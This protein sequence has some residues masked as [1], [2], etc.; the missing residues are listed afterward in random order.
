MPVLKPL[1]TG[2]RSLVPAARLEAGPILDFGGWRGSPAP[3][4]APYILHLNTHRMLDGGGASGG[5]LGFNQHPTSNIRLLNAQSRYLAASRQLEIEN[6]LGDEHGCKHVGE[7]A[8]HQSDG[9]SAH[10]AGSEHEQEG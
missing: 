6:H 2:S 1:D 10:G 3:K 7:Q 5:A 8:D 4:S 9:E